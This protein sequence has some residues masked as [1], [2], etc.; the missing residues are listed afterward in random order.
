MSR[1][2]FRADA[3]QD[4]I[5]SLLRQIP[6]VRVDVIG[7]P[8]DLLVGYRGHNF[9]IEVKNKNG[10]DTL[11]DAQRKFIPDWTGQ[12]RV[13]HTFDEILELIQGAYK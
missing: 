4:E 12:V 1:R 11:T 5:V 13:V 9:L 10:R 7:R 8:V 6:G 2:R 3:N